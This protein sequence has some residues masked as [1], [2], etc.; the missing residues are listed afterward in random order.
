MKGR[1]CHDIQN[2]IALFDYRNRLNRLN[3]EYRT[4]FR[5]F[6]CYA[7]YICPNK[8]GRCVA[9]YKNAKLHWLNGEYHRMNNPAIVHTNGHNTWSKEWFFKGLRH[10]DPKD[11]PA[12]E[13]LDNEKHYYFN[14]YIHRNP[15]DGPARI[16]ANGFMEFYEHGIFL[17]NINR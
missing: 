7:T 13:S 4:V 5:F 17:Y 11:G 6:D 14:G 16:W 8:R 3:N 9:I 15:K 1:L 2:I 10:R 12:I